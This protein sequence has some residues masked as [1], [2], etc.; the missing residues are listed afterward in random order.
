MTNFELKN[1]SFPVFAGNLLCVPTMRS[2]TDQVEIK[3]SLP[4]TS[5]MTWSKSLLS[6]PPLLLN[7]EHAPPPTVNGFKATWRACAE[8]G[9]LLGMCPIPPQLPSHPSM[10]HTALQSTLFYSLSTPATSVCIQHTECSF[11]ARHCAESRA[12]G[13]CVGKCASLPPHMETLR[14][15]RV[16]QA[17]RKEREAQTQGTVY[18]K[19]P[20]GKSLALEETEKLWWLELRGQLFRGSNF[21]TCCTFIQWN[22]IE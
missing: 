17:Q 6:Q 1:F 11:C 7:H 20:S 2:E 18:T 12:L 19:P 22:I 21:K 8:G 10:L 15:S 16:G 3:S 14:E 4:L 13:G 9:S 5:C